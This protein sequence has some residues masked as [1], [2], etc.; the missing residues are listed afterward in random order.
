MLVPSSY[1]CRMRTSPIAKI[2]TI[3]VAFAYLAGCT[4][5]NA[6]NSNS[7]ASEPNTSSSSADAPKDNSEE[8]E[9]LVHLPIPAEDVSWKET[10]PDPSTSPDATLNKRLI[11]VLLF[12]RENAAKLSEDLGRSHPPIAENLDPDS[13]YPAELIAQSNVRGDGKLSGQSYAA[14][15]FL[16]AAV[17]AGQDHAYR[18]H[19]LF[20]S[21][22][23]RPLISASSS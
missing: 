8:F 22:A 1:N 4:G 20:Y 6:A 23:F 5:K 19:G 16:A 7:P 15:E 18:Q 10:A 2:L 9:Q 17:H 13:W 12:T 3:F 14:D 11:A 21:G